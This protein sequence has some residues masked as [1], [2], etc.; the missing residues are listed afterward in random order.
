MGEEGYSLLSVERERDWREEEQERQRG[1]YSPMHIIRS[2]RWFGFC[3]L[4][5]QRDN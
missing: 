5:V 3:C 2:M 1:Q 4:P